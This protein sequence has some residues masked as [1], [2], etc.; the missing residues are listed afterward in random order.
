[1]NITNSEILS[2]TSEQLNTESSNTNNVIQSVWSSVSSSPAVLDSYVYQDGLNLVYSESDNISYS[3]ITDCRQALDRYF[4]FYF[5]QL[6]T[7]PDV[8]LGIN[9]VINLSKVVNYYVQSSNIVIQLSD[10]ILTIACLNVTHATNH[11]N[12][13]DFAV[14]NNSYEIASA[15]KTPIY[16]DEDN[17]STLTAA[18]NVATSSNIVVVDKMLSESVILRNGVD[19]WFN[20]GSGNEYNSESLKLFYTNNQNVTCNIYGYGIF[21]NNATGGNLDNPV[22]L[23]SG[24]TNINIGFQEINTASVRACIY[25]EGSFGTVTMRAKGHTMTG[26]PLD[27]DYDTYL[28][29]CDAVSMKNI[30]GGDVVIYPDNNLDTYYY[31]RNAF[32]SNDSDVY[33][34]MFM[35]SSLTSIYDINLI[36]VRAV[37]NGTMSVI[38]SPQDETHTVRLFNTYLKADTQPIHAMYQTTNLISYGDTNIINVENYADANLTGTI[39]IDSNLTISET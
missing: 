36:N 15:G 22:F 17:Y 11:L 6:A 34:T 24:S 4:S 20:A 31:I 32:M 25:A 29:D 26:R 14:K 2:A 19:I 13:L 28:V 23:L 5:R 7:I 8:S 10:Q 12:Y 39:I 33:G 3:S 27:S 1:L 38:D 16:V 21:T 30:D 37:N 35:Q 9:Y 18:L